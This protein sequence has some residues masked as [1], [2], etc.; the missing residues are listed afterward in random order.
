MSSLT[1]PEMGLLAKTVC[2]LTLQ[3]VCQET[4]NYIIH[5]T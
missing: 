1:F 5:Q 3:C 2:N 4:N